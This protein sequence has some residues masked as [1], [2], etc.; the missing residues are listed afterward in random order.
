MIGSSVI[1]RSAV[2]L[3]AAALIVAVAVWSG[4][5]DLGRPGDGPGRDAPLAATGPT[6]HTQHVRVG[7]EADFVAGMVPRHHEALEAAREVRAVVERPG[8]RAL[9]EDVERAQALE[10]ARLEAWM[11]EYWPERPVRRVA[12]PMMRP[13]TGLP[14]HEAEV[15]FAQGLIEHHR[16]ASAMAAAYLALEAPRRREIEAWAR[17]LERSAEGEIERLR[18]L[19][20]TSEAGSR[21]RH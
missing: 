20:D 16:M 21:V 14:P 8:V 2:L 17:D 13:L 11:A 15:A 6:D 12:V 18:A 9:A 1:V 7:S 3:V 4:L 10:I 19:L 5:P